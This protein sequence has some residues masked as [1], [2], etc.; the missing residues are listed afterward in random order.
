MK[1]LRMKTEQHKWMARYNYITWQEKERRKVSYTEDG[2]PEEIL[3]KIMDM[4]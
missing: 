1:I 4:T 2:L 3:M